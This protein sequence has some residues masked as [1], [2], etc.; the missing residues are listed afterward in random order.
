V[1]E[2]VAYVL[3]HPPV[4][5]RYRGPGGTVYPDGR[6]RRDL[7]FIDM[8]EHST[9]FTGAQ[10]TISLIETPSGVAGRVDAQAVWLPTRSA[11]TQVPLPIE[12]IDV[13]RHSGSGGPVS[14]TITGQQAT[15][16]AV[17][18]NSVRAANPGVRSCPGETTPP[19]Y[20]LLTFHSRSARTTLFVIRL[21]ACGAAYVQVDGKAQL[22]Y[23]DPESLPETVQQILLGQSAQ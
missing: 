11:N 8:Q 14:R 21:G 19:D 12:S 18:V 23:L 3:A 2:A 22:P 17:K 5:L 10:L 1:D 6:E 20:D 13:A 16:L 9:A 4:D 7:T 15:D